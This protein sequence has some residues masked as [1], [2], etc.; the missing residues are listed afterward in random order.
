[1]KTQR[2]LPVI[3]EESRWVHLD[4]WKS[5]LQNCAHLRARPAQSVLNSLAQYH[6]GQKV[7]LLCSCSFAMQKSL[8][9]TSKSWISF[10]STRDASGEGG[11][12]TSLTWHQ[13]DT[14]NFTSW[15]QCFKL[16]MQGF[17]TRETADYIIFPCTS[18]REGSILLPWIW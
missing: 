10:I 13:C 5:F 16:I 8:S 17:E 9:Y 12:R 15:A 1:M 11:Q 7:C 18:G 3:L 2:T 4:N 6:K 14:I